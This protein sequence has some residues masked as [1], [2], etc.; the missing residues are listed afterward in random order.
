MLGSNICLLPYLSDIGKIIQK[1]KNYEYKYKVQCRLRKQ[2]LSVKTP[3]VHKN[4][5]V[6]LAEREHF[7]KS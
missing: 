2:S 4:K 3:N 6:K 5:F 1:S 7:R